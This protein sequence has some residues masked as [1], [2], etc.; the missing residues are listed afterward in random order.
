MVLS[1]AFE[2]PDLLVAVVTGVWSPRDQGLLVGWI[3]D[4]IR[5]HGAVRVLV[6]L[7][8]FGGLSPISATDNPALWLRDDERIARMAFVGDTR[9]KL[10][11]LTVTAQ[12][13]R[14]FPIQYFETEA[15]ARQWLTPHVEER[16]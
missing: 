6:V 13:I 16:I 3:R 1:K 8:A 14:G 9:W 4:A 7:D 15:A 10:P 11:M 5:A 12:P 2:P